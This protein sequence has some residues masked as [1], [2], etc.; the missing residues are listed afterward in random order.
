M[1]KNNIAYIQLMLC[2]ILFGTSGVFLAY[3]PWN[4][5]IASCLRSVIMLL[6]LAVLFKTTG[7]KLVLNKKSIRTGICMSATISFFMLST[8]FTNVTNTTMLQY[9]APMQMLVMS[10]VLFK[11]PVRRRDIVAVAFVAIGIF[12]F[13]CEQITFDGMLGNLFGVLSGSAYALMYMTN[14][15]NNENERFSAQVVS[16]LGNI[17]V[18][19]PVIFAAGS[20]EV[21]TQIV[22]TLLGFA[23]LQ[24][25]TPSILYSIA[26]GKCSGLV[27]GMIGAAEPM[28]TPIWLF[29]LMGEVPT[30]LAIVGGV[31]VIGTI[32]IWSLVDIKRETMVG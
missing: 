5:L 16:Q 26:S 10:A 9:T 6:V 3:I 32:T 22:V 13:F 28:M 19:I 7:K 2:P 24:Y 1:K 12:V 30:A 11:T 8:E 31:M 18:G 27:C 25:A 23:L 15:N 21:N 29:F 4:A 20:L 17:L 14:E